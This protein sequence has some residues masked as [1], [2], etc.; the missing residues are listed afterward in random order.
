MIDRY[1]D[2]ERVMV[3]V[4]AKAMGDRKLLAELDGDPDYQPAKEL[5]GQVE[6]QR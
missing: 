2:D 5:V 1:Y 6:R 4:L 3:L